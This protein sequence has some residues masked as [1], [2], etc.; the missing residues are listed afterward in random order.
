MSKA[1]STPSQEL[2]LPF[3]R[4]LA[5]YAQFEA[6]CPDRLAAA[7][8]YSLIAGGKRLRPLLVLHA[9][10]ICGAAPEAAMPAACAVEMVHVYSLIHDDLPAM[11][12][13][14]MRRGKPSCHLAFDE[15]TAILAGDAL[16]ARAF[17]ILA[18]DIQPP[19]CAACCC[20]ELAIAA[21]PSQL[22]GGQ[23]D[24]LNPQ[25]TD[26]E[27]GQLESI[28]RRKTAALL[29]V[30]LRLGAIVAE[31][32]AG[33]LREITSFG[34]KL[35]LAFQV[36]DDLLDLQGNDAKLGKRTGQDARQGKRTFPALLGAAE[37]RRRADQL[38][39]EAI[40]HLDGFGEAA[41]PLAALAEYIVQRDH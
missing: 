31:S 34:K 19:A 14:D 32:T 1:T 22:V 21:G 28:N 5:R 27:L 40:A 26:D 20:A 25:P 24:D 9:A 2:L 30:S 37:S 10:A 38:A 39:S 11:D 3:E 29:T 33:Q 7:I 35:G 15:A 8:R 4:S 17:E 18:T 6:G 12:N 13:D 16:L 36:V 41:R 23:C